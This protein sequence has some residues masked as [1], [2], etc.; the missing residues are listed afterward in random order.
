MK[1]FKG[2]EIGKNQNMQYRMK[3]KEDSERRKPIH[4][5]FVGAFH[6]PLYSSGCY[7]GPETQKIKITFSKTGLYIELFWRILV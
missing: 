3:V 2:D 4:N 5:T 6:E 7:G 1:L